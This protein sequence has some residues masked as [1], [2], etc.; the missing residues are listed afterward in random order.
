M[1]AFINDV[2]DD[3]QFHQLLSAVSSSITSFEKKL[4]SEEKHNCLFLFL[5]STSV[6]L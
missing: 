2:Q 3:I 5:L 1:A 4:Q 6:K